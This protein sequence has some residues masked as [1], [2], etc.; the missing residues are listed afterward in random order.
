MQWIKSVFHIDTTA[1]ETSKVQEQALYMDDIILPSDENQLTCLTRKAYHKP[2][3]STSPPTL[4]I[5]E[6]DV[7][8]GFI[9]LDNDNSI[10]SND[11]SSS[12]E[13]DA[14]HEDVEGIHH[15]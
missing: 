3:Q 8:P 11:N 14:S 6:D 5:V 12:G 7:P 13:T 9:S 10:N 4:C 15:I 1:T 2:A